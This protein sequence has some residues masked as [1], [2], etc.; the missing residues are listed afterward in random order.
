MFEKWAIAIVGN[1]F[2]SQ[3]IKKN[4]DGVLHKAAA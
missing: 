4:I 1:H 2:Y 3:G